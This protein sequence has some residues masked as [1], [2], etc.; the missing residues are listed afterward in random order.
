MRPDRR[1]I[2]QHFSCL[3]NPYQPIF[4]QPLLGGY[5]PCRRRDDSLTKADGNPFSQILDPPVN[6]LAAAFRIFQPVAIKKCPACGFPLKTTPWTMVDVMGRRFGQDRTMS[7]R[8]GFTL[9]VAE[10]VFELALDVLNAAVVPFAE[11]RR[12]E[13]VKQPIQVSGD[14]LA[15][16]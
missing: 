7:W 13:T 6:L 2:G 12:R 9:P 11:Q 8:F 5:T 3:D 4:K 10:I 1:K 16:G 14:L 15:A